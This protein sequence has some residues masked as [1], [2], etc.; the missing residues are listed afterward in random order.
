MSD[1]PRRV[2]SK[3]YSDPAWDMSVGLRVR[4]S[5]PDGPV[6][7]VAPPPPSPA[8][9]DSVA[10]PP[11]AAPKPTTTSPVRS[12]TPS[13]PPPRPN[14]PPSPPAATPP[15]TT[16]TPSTT[17]GPPSAAVQMP[18]VPR[19]LPVPAKTSPTKT[20]KDHKRA[21]TVG[22]RVD[23]VVA[24]RHKKQTVTQNPAVE[25][26]KILG[27]EHVSFETLHPDDAF[28]SVDFPQRASLSTIFLRQLS[29][30]F[31]LDTFERRWK[32]LPG[33]FYT[34]KGP[35]RVDK[36]VLVKLLAYQ[37]MITGKQQR[38]VEAEK[39]KNKNALRTAFK[40]AIAKQEKRHRGHALGYNKALQLHAHFW[41]SPDYC[42]IKEI[43]ANLQSC[44]KS[45][46]ESLAGDEKLFEYTGLS[47][48]IRKKGD[49]QVGLWIYEACASLRNGLPLLLYLRLHTANKHV[50]ETV[51]VH[52]VVQDWVDLLHQKG[53]PET[54]LAHDHY[55][56]SKEARD[57]I[58][59][60]S[61]KVKVI[62][63]VSGSERFAVIHDLVKKKVTESGEWAAAYNDKTSEFYLHHHDPERGVGKK[64]LWSV[65]ALKVDS[66]VRRSQYLIPGYDLYGQIFSTCDRF[67]RRL[68]DR[69]FPHRY[70]GGK[71]GYGDMSAFFDFIRSSVLQ[72]TFNIF[73]QLRGRDPET[74]NFGDYC[75]MLANELFDLV[76]K[77]NM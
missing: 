28:V 10:S 38:P 21:L 45:L 49:K 44:I 75:E 32:E 61:P 5:Q 42:E 22:E 24:K 9:M 67:N 51:P 74:M 40:E 3:R 68:H 66:R 4:K 35:L 77:G 47:Y 18:S 55:Y 41:V 7:P 14:T 52:L 15:S 30:T 76:V 19:R 57:T 36:A 58:M 17:P 26:W 2:P 33:N 25:D 53:K 8:A 54:I 60:A 29:P 16:S 11:P 64:S 6:L 65:N 71:N 43:N 1:R 31:L 23:N 50:G 39:K 59:N 27:E 37:I 34:P 73:H 20:M 48:L 56:F 69:T 70:G 13:A 62:A 12:A 72:N 46:G 63:S